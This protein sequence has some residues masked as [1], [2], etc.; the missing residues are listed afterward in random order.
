MGVC[1]LAA[2]EARLG[3]SRSLEVL[4]WLCWQQWRVLLCRGVSVAVTHQPAAF[5]SLGDEGFK[6]GNIK[7]IP[8]V[9]ECKSTGYYLHLK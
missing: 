4:S 9:K 5:Q 1:S 8:T 7:I 6:E 2:R 3:E